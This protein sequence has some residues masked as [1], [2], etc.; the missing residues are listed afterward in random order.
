MFPKCGT[1]LRRQHRHWRSGAERWDLQAEHS[2]D[3]GVNPYTNYTYASP[4]SPHPER[5][6]PTCTQNDSFSPGPWVAACLCNSLCVTSLTLHHAVVLHQ[7]VVRCPRPPNAGQFLRCLVRGSQNHRI[8]GVGRDLCGSS[9]PTPPAKAGS[10]TA[11]CTGP[12][13]GGS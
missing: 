4:L 1:S 2:H 5:S 10:P 12:C 6:Q 11:G 3:F 9:S 8:A 7:E 13:P